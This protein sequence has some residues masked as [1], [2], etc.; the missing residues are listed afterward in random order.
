MAEMKFESR[1]VIPGDAITEVN[2]MPDSV[3]VVL[4]PG[5]YRGDGE[6]VAAN[7]A[8]VLRHKRAA[9]EA[10]S[11][12]VFWVDSH[13]K[14]L[15]TIVTI[16]QNDTIGRRLL[17][18]VSF[19][20]LALIQVLR[21]YSFLMGPPLKGRSLLRVD[22]RMGADKSLALKRRLSFIGG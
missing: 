14:R 6:R 7:R 9:Q 10:L 8:G 22:G 19:K 17:R 5:L 18:V 11:A 2:S 20:G 3:P 13:S 1:I 4:G 15:V 16:T 21:F 12:N